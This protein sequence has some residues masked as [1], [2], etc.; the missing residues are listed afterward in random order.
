[1]TF[2]DNEIVVM[3]AEACRTDVGFKSWTI[4]TKHLQVFAE[5]VAANERMECSK[6]CAELGEWACVH[7][8]EARGEKA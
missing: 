7:A 5:M 2:T 3:A 6:A 8:I 1:M 4:S